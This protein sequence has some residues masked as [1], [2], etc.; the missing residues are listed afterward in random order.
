MQRLLNLGVKRRDHIATLLPNVHES[1]ESHYA[2]SKL[3]CVIVAMNTR[4]SPGEL[5]YIINHSDSK[6]LI[7][8]W[9]YAHLIHP[10]RDRL[11]NIRGIIITSGGLKSAELEGLDCESILGG[12]LAQEIGLA[13]DEDTVAS[14]LYTSGTT[15]RPKGA[16]ITP[17][18]DYMRMLQS[19]VVLRAW[20]DDIY[21]HLV[22]IFHAQAWGRQYGV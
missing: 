16:V 18:Q 15:A 6:F 7:V 19:L 13:E 9:E 21:L 11:P 10:I 20:R 8:D 12:A 14:I 4:L 22:P 1:M 17:R 5:E 2:I 3:D